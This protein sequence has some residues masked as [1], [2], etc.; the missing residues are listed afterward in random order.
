[1]SLANFALVVKICATDLSLTLKETLKKASELAT[2]ANCTCVASLIAS[3]LTRPAVWNE[4][5][6]TTI[7]LVRTSTSIL[8]FVF[9]TES[10]L[11]CPVAISN[12]SLCM[13]LLPGFTFGWKL[14]CVLILQ[15]VMNV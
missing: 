3:Q 15:E 6:H 10:L 7:V 11:F 4:T 5:A 9:A 2:I 1:M 14:K 8:V 12:N 13:W